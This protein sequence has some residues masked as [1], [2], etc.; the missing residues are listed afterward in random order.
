MTETRKTGKIARFSDQSKQ[1]KGLYRTYF[2]HVFFGGPGEAQGHLPGPG[3]LLRHPNGG[4]PGARR[5][6]GRLGSLE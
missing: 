6:L 2:W 1:Q 5:A 3:T 4:L